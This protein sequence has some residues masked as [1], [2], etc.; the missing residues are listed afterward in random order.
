MK[1]GLLAKLAVAFLSAVSPSLAAAQPALPRCRSVHELR[2]PM[3]VWSPKVTDGKLSSTPP[4]G[5]G[6]IVYIDLYSDDYYA[7]CKE[8]EKEKVYIFEFL[9]GK[10]VGSGGLRVNIHDPKDHKQTSDGATCIFMGFYSNEPVNDA[11]DGWTET[12][13]WPV[14]KFEIMS[15]GRYCLSDGRSVPRAEPR[16]S[17]PTCKRSGEDRTPVPVWQPKRTPGGDLRSLP[18]MG[19]GKFVYISVVRDEDCSAEWPDRPYQLSISYQY[20]GMPSGGFGVTLIG[21]S[22]SQ[23]GHCVWSGIY[24]NQTTPG[25]HMG[26]AETTFVGVDTAKLISSGQFC[27]VRPDAAARHGARR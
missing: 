18:P 13:F 4:Q 23:N 7:G 3:P 22:G 25:L 17:L 11:H 5:K 16:D 15:S 20:K 24:M 27:L 8:P 10:S 2:M 1:N 12:N 9:H 14:D 21:N 19:D 6:R 26:W